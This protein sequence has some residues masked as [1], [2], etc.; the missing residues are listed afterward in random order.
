[1]FEMFVVHDHHDLQ[2]LKA[3]ILNLPGLA[4]VLCSVA[5]TQSSI[6]HPTGSSSWPVAACVLAFN[7]S[8]R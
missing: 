2:L 8:I 5:A 1:M 4:F 7:A 6:G 3:G